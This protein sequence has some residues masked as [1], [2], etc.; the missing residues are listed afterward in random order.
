[1][2]LWVVNVSVVLFALSVALSVHDVQHGCSGDLRGVVV[3]ARALRAGLDPYFYVWRPGMSERLADYW[4]I[5]YKMTR[6][7]YPPSLLWFYSLTSGWGW[8]R[9]RWVDFLAEE[10]AFLA[11]ALL[12]ARSSFHR[13][14]RER[15]LSLLLVLVA[16]GCSPI[17]RSHVERG[18]HYVGLAL[19]LGLAL[20]CVERRQPGWAGFCGGW[21]VLF[22]PTFAVIFLPLLMKRQWRAVAGGAAGLAVSLALSLPTTGLGLYQSA[23]RALADWDI[24]YG[25]EYLVSS[26]YQAAPVPARLQ[27][28]RPA[29]PEVLEGVR[30][31]PVWNP[32]LEEHFSLLGVSNAMI[33]A[34]NRRG[35]HVHIDPEADFRLPVFRAC[36][37]ALLAGVCLALVR[38]RGP[39]PGSLLLLVGFFLAFLTDLMTVAYRGLY[40]EVLQALSLGVLGVLLVDGRLPR[41]YRWCGLFGASW[42]LLSYLAA[43][44]RGGWHLWLTLFSW[45]GPYCAL[46]FMG[47]AVLYLVRQAGREGSGAAGGT[48]CSG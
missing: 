46:V 8:S 33:F 18:Q 26:P 48:T 1:V 36:C 22:R 24:S 37:A 6:A 23:R 29:T 2:N 38:G 31:R 12:L 25:Q 28:D 45:V 13:T 47:G 15:A 30:R 21:A 34:A 10:A 42:A 35:A 20:A 16:I 4:V 43:P 7:T 14:D 9:L 32:P 44:V 39:I 27:E 40:S 17:W 5:P 19:L 3:A 11:L 41:F